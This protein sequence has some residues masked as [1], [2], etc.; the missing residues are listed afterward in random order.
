MSVSAIT[1]TTQYLTFKLGEE[2]F[3]LDVAK[4]REILDFTTVTKVPQTPDYMR[5]VINLRGSVVPVVDLRL[6]FGMSATEKT[7]NTCVIVVEM[8][9]EGEALVLGRPGRLGAGGDRPGAGADR[10]GAAHR[11]HAQHRLHQGHGQAQREVHHDPGHR[12]GVFRRGGGHGA[13]G[14]GGTHRLCRGLDFAE[15][16][17]NELYALIY[18]P[19]NFF[20]EERGMFKNM[21]IGLR[22]GLGFGMLLMLLGIMAGVSYQKLQVLDHMINKVVNDRF[23]KTVHAMEMNDAVNLTAR[24]IRNIVL[25]SDPEHIEQQ[26]EHL[27]QARKQIDHNMKTL[28]DTIR[29]E[30]GKRQLAALDEA[31]GSYRELEQEY[32]GLVKSEKRDQALQLLMGK[33]SKAQAQYMDGIKSL[34]RFQTEQVHEA[35]KEADGMTS[36]AV[37]LVV[38]LAAGA[39]LLGLGLAFTITRSITRPLSAC[40]TA[41]GKIAGGDMNVELDDTARDETGQLQ[42]AMTTMAAAMK[43]LASDAG[44]LADAA[45][46]GRL[47]I[48]ADAARH[49]GDFRR[50]VEGMNDVINR[51]VGLLDS[52]PTPAMIIDKDFTILY[53]NELGA[54]VAGKTPAADPG[55]PS[56]TTTSRPRTAAASAAPATGP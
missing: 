2:V 4:V 52:M 42:R 47:N 51:L 1:E 27:A 29:G 46:A 49:Q 56:V 53:M 20:K 6:K 50:I 19:L 15:R 54:K 45:I 16:E 18:L 38:A 3:A 11:H 25:S 55:R 44:A 36:A 41:A 21:R 40:I 8:M 37:K 10:A 32:L 12:Q 33:L 43:A 23:P 22:L 34:V 9:L 26:Y 39:F 31:A 48:R 14:C 24:A 28:Q 17:A 5:G 30:E 7:V 35:G 13:G